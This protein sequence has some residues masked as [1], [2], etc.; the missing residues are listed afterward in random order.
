MNVCG[1]RGIITTKL[2]DMPLPS[3]KRQGLG[4]GVWRLV[5]T[6]CAEGFCLS[7]GSARVCPQSSV[8][9]TLLNTDTIEWDSYAAQILAST[10][11]S[12]SDIA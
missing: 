3:K 4:F 7:A 8:P 11:P 9:T 6:G 1:S 5:K 2:T 12:R 10:G